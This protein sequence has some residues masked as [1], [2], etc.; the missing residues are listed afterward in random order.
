MPVQD[1]Q[2]LHIYRRSPGVILLLF[3]FPSV[4]PSI[5][6]HC[7]KIL[8]GQ[9]SDKCRFRMGLSLFLH[10]EQMLLS[11]LYWDQT[12]WAPYVL[13]DLPWHIKIPYI[14]YHSLLLVPPSPP[15][16]KNEPQPNIIAH[17]FCF[18]LGCCLRIFWGKPSPNHHPLSFP[19]P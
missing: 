9:C 4:Y 19:Y 2:I 10:I 3:S 6:Y 13:F 1:F 11:F 12:L 7:L 15:L 17:N 18:S 8:M 5:P 14:L 16:C